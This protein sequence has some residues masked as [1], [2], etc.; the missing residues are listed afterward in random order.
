MST[1]K[2]TS[3][4]WSPY[5]RTLSDTLEKVQKRAAQNM[6]HRYVKKESP[7]EMLKTLAWG[8]L[9]QRH[10]KARLVIGYQML[11]VVS[12]TTSSSQTQLQPEA[13]TRSTYSYMQ[14]EIITKAHFSPLSTHYRNGYQKLVTS[15]TSL[16]D[17][18]NKLAEIHISKP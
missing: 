4:V 2:Y 12:Q 13:T 5:Q 15:A 18:R 14:K 17:F 3:T 8:T 16:E 6:T 1:V 10:M 11:C 9:V 7:T